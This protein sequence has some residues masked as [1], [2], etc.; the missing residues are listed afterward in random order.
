M[1]P[2]LRVKHLL[3]DFTI[4]VLD[5]I[6]GPD[7][8]DGDYVMDHSIVFYLLDPEG[9]YACYF[10]GMHRETVPEM[11]DK[12]RRFKRGEEVVES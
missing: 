5:Y 1:K 3:L 7:D 4:T 2:I 8:Q 6:T 12:I 11:A 9:N 10:M